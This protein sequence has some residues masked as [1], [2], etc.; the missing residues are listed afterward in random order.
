MRGLPV[1][2]CG[3]ALARPAEIQSRTGLSLRKERP[4]PP[5]PALPGAEPAAGGPVV[6]AA[7]KVQ[8]H[9]EKEV[10]ESPKW[11][12]WVVLLVIAG[13]LL[14]FQWKFELFDQYTLFYVWGRNVIAIAAYLMIV[15]VAFQDGLG[16]GA[17]CLAIP[18]YLLVY[19]GSS[20]E[21]G[22]LRGMIFGI[23]L[24]L[25]GEMFLL[26]EQSLFVAMGENMNEIIDTVDSL[27]VKAS[28]SP[29]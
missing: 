28:D 14:G 5:P 11:V 12:P 17:L 13:G 9:K 19:A 1:N 27:I 25:I 3:A 15:L 4:D 8:T 23:S 26:P 21:S 22:I 18:P 16:P 6:H 20:V 2:T 7:P 24:A 10:R 29:I